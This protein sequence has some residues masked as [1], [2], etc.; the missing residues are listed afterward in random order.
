MS[1][2]VSVQW[3]ITQQAYAYL[4]ARADEMGCSMSTVFHLILAGHVPLPSTYER[5]QKHRQMQKGKAR[6]KPLAG[7]E[8]SAEIAGAPDL[9]DAD[10]FLKDALDHTEEMPDDEE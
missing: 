1:G 8:D 9:W 6:R 10:A 4:K 7:H 2:K 3:R 5:Q